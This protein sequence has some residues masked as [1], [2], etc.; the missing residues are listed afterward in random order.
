MSNDNEAVINSPPAM[1]SP[2][3]PQLIKDARMLII[4]YRADMKA[5]QEVLP[6]GLEAHP[7]GLV[8]M[9]MYEVSGEQTSG[10]GA[11]SLTYL[12]VEVANHDSYA[13]EGTMP[14]P[15]RYFAYYWNSSARVRAYVRESV[16]VRAMPGD[17]RTESSGGK[18]QSILN[19]EGRDVIRVKAALNETAGG[20]LGGH[21]NY[22]SHREFL[23][24]EGGSPVL[25]E[26]LE[27]PLPFVA[28][29]YDAQIEDIVF[30][31]PDGHPASRL[32]PIAPL[33][34]PAIMH[35]DVTFTYSMGRRLQNYLATTV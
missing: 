19:V 8:Q 30:D 35:A 5:I 23:K 29:L 33:E 4:G 3:S 20:T 16:G 24:P 14:I 7:N 18:F 15:G 17:R 32:A 31:F 34:T 1:W 26:L 9:N 21:L 22:Y 10:F 13:A 12:T 2:P 6:S 11:F 25:S 28:N 27:F